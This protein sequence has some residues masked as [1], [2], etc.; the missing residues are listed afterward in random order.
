M[1]NKKQHSAAKQIACLSFALS[2]SVSAVVTPAN[3]ASKKHDSVRAPMMVYESSGTDKQSNDSN[4][5][6]SNN[7]VAAPLPAAASKQARGAK[8]AVAAPVST[9]PSVT[10]GAA[11]LLGGSSLPTNQPGS[12]QLN[13]SQV[14]IAI[15]SDVTA[16]ASAFGSITE[17]SN[18]N[19]NENCPTF[20]QQ[21]EVLNGWGQPGCTDLNAD[22]TTDAADLAIFL[23]NGFVYQEPVPLTE[24]EEQYIVD[25]IDLTYM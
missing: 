25:N 22:G 14:P 6:V 2:L 10:N 15:N 9:S 12:T 7:A 1:Y 21:V 3:A 24:C 5:A 23:G 19:P 11:P 4:V 8:S 20:T 17:P 18:A 16:G 13:V